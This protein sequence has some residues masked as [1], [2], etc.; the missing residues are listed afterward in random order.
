[1]YMKY[2]KRLF[3]LI[4]SSLILIMVSP[5]LIL[6]YLLIYFNLGKPCIFK[7]ERPGYK[8]RVFTL[9]KF[10]TMK[11]LY[12][13]QNNLLPD[14]DRL[15]VFGKFLR[16]TSLDELPELLNVLKG[17]MSLIGPRPLLKEY[18]PY[19]SPE[20]ARRHDVIPG[21]TG[22]AQIH[23]RNSLSWEDKFKW[24]IYYVDNLSF[25]LDLKIIFRTLATVVKSQGIHAKDHATMPRFNENK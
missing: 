13:S 4:F 9:Y 11:N 1:M 23:G 18:L 15:T 2:F 7:Q 5:L 21:I 20:Q 17:E 3:D 14:A 6:I 8:G 10:V 12:D 22:L 19:Y 16:K 24:D 25:F